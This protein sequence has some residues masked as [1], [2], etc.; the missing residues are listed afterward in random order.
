MASSF[1]PCV[2]KRRD[3]FDGCWL[4]RVG[5]CFWVAAFG[6]LVI[7]CCFVLGSLLRRG[8]FV[9]GWCVHSSFTL[10]GGSMLGLVASMNGEGP[11]HPLLYYLALSWNRGSFLAEKG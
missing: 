9:L 8:W 7:G 3:V 1:L 5:Y 10:G 6:V 11:I 2:A 4:L